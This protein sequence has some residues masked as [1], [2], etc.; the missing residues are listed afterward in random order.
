[1]QQMMW[2]EHKS[3]KTTIEDR[4]PN[5]QIVKQSKKLKACGYY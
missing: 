1:M 4:N 2:P 3:T 5:K